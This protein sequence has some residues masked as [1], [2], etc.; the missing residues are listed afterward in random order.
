MGYKLGIDFGTTSIKISLRGD[1]GLPLDVF[2]GKGT[3]Q[4]P[5]VVA[6]QINKEER[7]DEI[8][9]GED[10]DS[11]A[12]E[13]VVVVREIKRIY[14]Y[15]DSNYAMP[16]KKYPW[17]DPGNN[18]VKIGKSNIK[19]EDIVLTILREALKRA[20]RWLRDND[21]T[22]IGEFDIKG[23]PIQ[24][25]CSVTAN[26]EIRR[27][28]TNIA[29]RLGISE[30][31]I[32][33]LAEESV[34][35]SLAFI[36]PLLSTQ[37]I[38]RGQIVLVYDLGGGTFDTSILRIDD[39]DSR[40]FPI[41][42]VFASDGEA[43]C[44]GADIDEAL[45]DYLFDKI[46]AATGEKVEQIKL[47]I[48]EPQHEQLIY[49]TRLLKER[50]SNENQVEVIWPLGFPE[51]YSIGLSI[52]QSDL[53]Q[54]VDRTGL[55]DKT[56]E[57]VLRAW[58]RARMFLRSRTEDVG[59]Y[60]L[61]QDEKTGILK[62]HILSIGHDDIQKW[63]NR[64]LIVGG[65]TLGPAVLPKLVSHWGTNKLTS[66]ETINPISA[67]ATGAAYQAGRD[68]DTITTILNHLPFSIEI[69]HEE[70]KRKELYQ[71]YTQV[72]KFR[73]FENKIVPYSRNFFISGTSKDLSVYYKGVNDEIIHEGQYLVIKGLN[74]IEMDMFG[75]INL[76]NQNGYKQPLPN[77][78][79]HS[80]QKDQIERMEQEKRKEREE[81]RNR[82]KKQLFK[83]PGERMDEVG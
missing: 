25:G 61:N 75:R 57:C 34:L 68:N 49:T 60:Y 8:A 47:S 14:A 77:D 62:G 78:S 15:K 71:A 6:Y 72:A 10:A 1:K 7:A 37:E 9:V 5:S 18:L 81:E 67:C 21:I 76:V 63:V 82:A 4:M 30:F 51:R 73:T 29:R 39:I 43:L 26:L 53:I 69:E 38:Q 16:T 54:I 22:D 70:I 31:K 45:T 42:T 11:A 55:V 33:H 2:V 41:L 79:Q 20:E 58:R 19:P 12:G 13:N 44:G 59:T 74:Y 56:L 83:K 32:N 17:W 3:R 35:A 23:L 50:L 27:M 80:L 48:N 52:T 40:G 66:Q 64:I 65:A 24:I 46:G 28:L 36:N